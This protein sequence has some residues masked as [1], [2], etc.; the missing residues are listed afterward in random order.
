MLKIKKVSDATNLYLANIKQK[1]KKKIMTK[2]N[3]IFNFI[4]LI[5]EAYFF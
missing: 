4:L 2:Q 5:F 3:M 1:I